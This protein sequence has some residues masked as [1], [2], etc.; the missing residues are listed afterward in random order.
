[1]PSLPTTNESLW[2]SNEQSLLCEDSLQYMSKHRLRNGIEDCF[3]REDESVHQSCSMKNQEQYRLKCL[4][5]SVKC[6]SSVL[7]ENRY[8]DCADYNDEQIVHLKWNL[9]KHSCRQRNSVKC[10]RLKTYIQS[11]SSTVL[12]RTNDEVVLYRQYCDSLFDLPNGSNDENNYPTVTLNNSCFPNKLNI[13]SFLFFIR[14]I[15]FFFFEMIDF[16]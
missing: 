6:L 2:H 4:D 13:S 3:S 14:Q 7:V 15:F 5:N 10:K 16:N 11:S 1:M 9:I 12:T 8:S